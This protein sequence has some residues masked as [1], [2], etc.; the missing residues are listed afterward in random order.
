MQNS[1]DRLPLFLEKL[2][3]FNRERDWEQFHSP[4]NLAMDVATEVGELLEHFRWLT[5]EKSSQLDQKTLDA[6]RDEIG[7]VFRALVYLS[8]KLGI[9]PIQAAEEKLEKT[10]KKYP[11]EKCRGKATKYTAYE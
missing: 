9:D 2:F 7:D 3:K 10:G 11:A 5:E 8:H 1:P 6:V 4:K